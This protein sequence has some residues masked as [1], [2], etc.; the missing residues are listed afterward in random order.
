MTTTHTNESDPA[1]K[2]PGDPRTLRRLFAGAATYTGLGLVSGV[3]YREFTKIQGS[4]EPTQLNTLHTHLL[5]LGMLVLLVALAIEALFATSR[6]GLFRWFQPV[7]HA[8]L[9]I[10][11][12]TMLVR[13]V[14]DVVGQPIESAALPG[15]AGLGHIL[16]TAGLIIWLISLGRQIG[17]L[18]R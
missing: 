12:V 17:T 4:T 16:I 15:I 10:T 18:N 3:F 6:Q 14:T 5:A 13:G 9:V 1:L 2:L 8:G 11:A 7:Y